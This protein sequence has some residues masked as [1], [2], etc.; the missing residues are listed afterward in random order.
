MSSIC[1]QLFSKTFHNTWTVCEIPGTHEKAMIARFGNRMNC[2]G[3]VIRNNNI[4]NQL[5]E[6]VRKYNIGEYHIAE[7][8][9]NK[10]HS[11]QIEIPETH[12]SQMR[13]NIQ[14]SSVE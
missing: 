12:Y 4:K 11:Y 13:E 14:Y 3:E 1:S 8:E 5:E 7:I 10:Q 6:F 9:E 2:N